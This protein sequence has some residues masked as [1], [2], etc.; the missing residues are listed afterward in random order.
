M[1]RIKLQHVLP[2]CVLIG[3]YVLSVG[4]FALYGQ[5]NLDADMSCEMI[6]ADLLNR[7]GRLLTDSWFYSTE[8]RTVSPIPLFQLGLLLFDSWHAARTFAVAMCLLVVMASFLYMSSKLGLCERGIYCASVVT[9]PFSHAYAYVTVYGCGYSVY[10]A[11]VFLLLGLLIRLDEKKG[12]VRRMVTLGILAL[13]GGTGG[14]RTMMIATVPMLLAGVLDTLPQMM[15]HEKLTEGLKSDQGMRLLGTLVVCVMSMLGL[16]M[17]E[18]VL[19]EAYDFTDYSGMGI[20]LRN[21]DALAEQMIRILEFFGFRESS[22]LVSAR[23]VA[24]V[25]ALGVVMLMGWAIVR[26]SKSAVGNGRYVFWFAIASVVL[27]I[28]INTLTENGYVRY[29]LPG[30]VMLVVLLDYAWANMPCKNRFIRQAVPLCIVAVFAL[31]AGIYMRQDLE[32][33]EAPYE[34]TAAWLQENGYAQGFATFWNSSMLTEA[35][36][37]EITV[38]AMDDAYWYDDWKQLRVREPLQIKQNRAYVEEQKALYESGITVS[39]PE[40]K[41]FVYLS[42]MELYEPDIPYARKENLVYQAEHGSVFAYESI[43]ALYETLKQ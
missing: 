31:E 22:A 28:V 8:I 35:S 13:W 20:R 42:A 14:I 6:Y 21:L 23:G 4:F 36:D 12:R 19:R 3:A 29:Y 15:K 34:E 17:N 11:L 9:L 10:L 40:D 43:G 16:I 41:V 37:G 30:L 2:W 33:T 7:E 38:Y 18:T 26:L 39:K 32:H 1:K 25:A 24:S 27:G 5:H